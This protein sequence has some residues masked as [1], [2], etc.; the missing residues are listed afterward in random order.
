MRDAR[1]LTGKLE[2]IRRL[3]SSRNGN[4]RYLLRVDGTTF[5]TAV[6]SSHGYS[7]TNHDGKSVRVT[8]GTH[9]GVATLADIEPA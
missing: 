2:V 5:R 6:D 1:T 4:P 9:Y 3:P 7:V 8:V